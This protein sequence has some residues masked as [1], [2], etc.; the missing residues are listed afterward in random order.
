MAI[1]HVLLD[2]KGTIL[3]TALAQA[4]GKGAPSSSGFL[5]RK[6]QRVVQVTIDDKV[7][8]LDAAALHKTVKTKLLAKATDV[9]NESGSATRTGKAHKP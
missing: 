3:G 2:E 4:S 8:S 1:M 5:A 7:A 6:G 9:T